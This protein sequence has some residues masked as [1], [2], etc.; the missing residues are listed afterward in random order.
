VS[1]GARQIR[2]PG[3]AKPRAR[4]GS[5]RTTSSARTTTAV[6]RQ[7][8]RKRRRCARA[9]RYR[10]ITQREPG[11]AASRR[12][13]SSPGR[14]VASP[15]RLP[16]PLYRAGRRLKRDL[17]CVA[18]PDRRG[19]GRTVLRFDETT[20]FGRNKVAIT[21]DA[22]SCITAGVCSAESARIWP[23][24]TQRDRAWMRT[25]EAGNR[26][27]SQS[28]LRE[29]ERAQRSGARRRRKDSP[30]RWRRRIRG[31]TLDVCGDDQVR[32]RPRAQ[33]VA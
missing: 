22:I 30:G 12:W 28:A 9:K 24:V 17:G 2:V 29:L 13:S 32:A 26:V 6:T 11:A 31:R 19:D 1:H 23:V 10:P 8:R 25:L 21:T 27:P 5:R 20:S 15:P 7:Q 33:A 4:T 18:D 14:A 3:S 16:G